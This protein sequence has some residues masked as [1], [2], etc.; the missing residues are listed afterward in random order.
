MIESRNDVIRLLAAVVA[1]A[2]GTAFAAVGFA[3]ES[4]LAL[5]WFG[6]AVLVWV[7]LLYTSPSPRDS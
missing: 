3:T 6:A 4:T 2:V 1:T 5:T 7:C